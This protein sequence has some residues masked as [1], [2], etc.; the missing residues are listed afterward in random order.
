MTTPTLTGKPPAHR[1]LTISGVFG[2]AAAPYERWSFRLNFGV[3]E[4]GDLVPLADTAV[5]NLTTLL[6]GIKTDARVTEV[7]AAS[8]DA[9]G[10]YDADPEIRVLDSP[11]TGTG[12]QPLPQV[13]LAVSLT[14]DR[15]G[16]TGRGRIYYPMPAA[17]VGAGG[18]FSAMYADT[19][20][21]RVA[22]F[23]SALNQ[24][25][26]F[27]NA[28]VASSKGYLTPVT[29]VRCGRVPDTMRSRRTSI[30]EDYSAISP[31]TS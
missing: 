17:D 23:L 15:R 12:G 16:P 25:A 21:Q 28:V 7:K 19:T 5:A 29:G 11:G 6:A 4:A 26:G 14:T 30:P 18:T 2:T 20:A 8:I 3:G 31:V 24:P 22:S 9:N 10:L 27:G 1:R 13:A